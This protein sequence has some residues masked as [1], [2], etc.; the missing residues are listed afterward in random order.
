M[1]DPLTDSWS[2]NWFLIHRDRPQGILGLSQ[3]SYIDTV[4][5]RFSMKDS[6]PGEETHQLLKETYSISNNAPLHILK[7]KRCKRFPMLR[8]WGVS[9]MLKYAPDPTRGGKKIHACGYPWIKS[10]MDTE[11]ITKR[12]STYIINEYLTTCYFMD[13][14]INLMILVPAS[15]HTR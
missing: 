6:K 14:D 3:R 10:V 8:L 5:D 9:Y 15:I 13:M 12:V 2:S 1:S 11:R 7:R 4:L